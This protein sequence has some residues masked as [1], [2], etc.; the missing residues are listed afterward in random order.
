MKAETS[1]QI[2]QK[3]AMRLEFVLLSL[4]FESGDMQYPYSNVQK[5]D[6]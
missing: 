2:P 4:V 6:W 1:R 5:V 3:L